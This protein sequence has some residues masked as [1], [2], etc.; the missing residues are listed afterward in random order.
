MRPFKSILLMS[1]VLVL[2]G[3]CT[4]N[5]AMPTSTLHLPS[6]W[7]SEVGPSHGSAEI[8]RVWWRSFDDPVLNKL[9]DEAL[10]GNADLRV[11]RTRV[12]ELRARSVVANAATLP[13]LTAQAQPGRQRAL[14]AFAQPFITNVVPVGVQAS[15]EIDVW[16]KLDAATD[17]ALAS[18]QAERAA[19]DAVALSI[20]ANVASA[21]LNLRGLD[22]QLELAEAT[23][24]LRAHSLKLAQRNFETGYSS[25]LEW[26]QAQAEY[27]STAELVPQLQRS[28]AEQENA[29]SLLSGRTPGLVS[30][31]RSLSELSIPMVPLGLP[32]ELIRRRPDIYRAER[33]LAAQ[34]ANL[35]VARDQLFPS[36]RLGIGAGF[37][38]FSISDLINAPTAVWSLA[39]GLSTPLYDG[40]R[41]R[42]Q[43]DIA[44]AQHEAAFYSYENTVRQALAETENG[45]TA[46]HRLG[47]QMDKVEARR[48][49]AAD[50]L[51]IARNRHANGYS[52]YLEELDAQRNLYSADVSILQIKA[53]SLIAAVDLYR[54]LGGGW[55]ISN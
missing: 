19:A 30:R 42:A 22:A 50:A 18:L 36:I 32:A 5:V 17:A 43:T 27:D 46:L 33:N 2:V 15:Y 14:N 44:A 40:G 37:Q 41:L 52:S 9:V 4:T 54:A 11:A 1:G 29:L 24:Q 51:R 49:S 13:T 3:G 20:A 31:G 53:R 10:E 38:N 39:I 16:G 23:L 28:I 6:G 35:E 47:E 8:E 26:L 48:Q 25:R 34:Y 55:Q 12:A 7:R 45:L 21:Y